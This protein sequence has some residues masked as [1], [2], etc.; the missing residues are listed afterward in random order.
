MQKVIQSPPMKQKSQ[1]FTLI[2]LLVVV[3]IIAVLISLLVPALGKAFATAKSTED[4]M[5]IKGIY[6]AM[7][8]DGTGNEGRFPRPS[9]MAAQYDPANLNHTNPTTDTTGNL[10]SLMI[11]RNYFMPELLLSPVETNPNIRDMNEN[12]AIY[13]FD[14]IDGESILWDEALEGDVANATGTNPAHN[15]YAHQAL[16]GERI[17]LKWHTGATASDVILSNRGP[18]SELDNSFFDTTSNT[19]KFHGDETTWSGNIVCG[20]G[21]TRLAGNRLPKGIAYQPLNGGQ[22][23]LDNIFVHDWNDVK[24]LGS[25]EPMASGDNWLVICTSVENENAITTVWD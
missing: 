1:G 19:L 4:K 22:L 14:S 25:P 15:S 11:A 16:C 21:S 13:D 6:G 8:L 2:E 12:D 20:D 10:M 9:A 23:D 18:L 24:V 7:V 17:R 5:Q 3:A